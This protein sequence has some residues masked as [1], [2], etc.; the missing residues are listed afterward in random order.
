MADIRYRRICFSL[1]KRIPPLIIDFVIGRNTFPVVNSSWFAFFL[2]EQRTRWRRLPPPPPG[3]VFGG[4]KKKTA[5]HSVGR[6][7]GLPV[8][9]GVFFFF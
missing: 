4:K 3:P 2:A 6:F 5:S 8:G 1:S 9:L 7:D